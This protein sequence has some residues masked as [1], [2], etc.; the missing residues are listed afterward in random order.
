MNLIIAVMA[1]LLFAPSSRAANICDSYLENCISENA[2]GASRSAWSAI[3]SYN[4]AILAEMSSKAEA[5]F[6]EESSA[7]SDIGEEDQTIKQKLDVARAVV[8]KEPLGPIKP[9]DG[10]FALETMADQAELMELTEAYET[11]FGEIDYAK[12]FERL[13]QPTLAGVSA[14]FSSVQATL[15]AAINAKTELPASARDKMIERVKRVKYRSAAQAVRAGN[16]SELQLECGSSYHYAG[17]DLDLDANTVTLCPAT[18]AGRK[19]DELIGSF[20]AALYE[21][22]DLGSDEFKPLYRGYLACLNKQ[23]TGQQMQLTKSDGEATATQSYWIFETIFRYRYDGKR[24][25][26]KTAKSL[27]IACNT[28]VLK[29][30]LM[31][32]LTTVRSYANHFNCPRNKPRCDL[33]GSVNADG[34]AG[35]N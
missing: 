20:A 23:G 1:S 16:I 19:P 25:E 10:N 2:A 6:M 21:A 34:E 14:A 3:R 22:A 4:D 5:A 17:F 32:S 11:K 29:D 8:R 12:V 24:D 30:P 13:E 31:T 26:A 18:I 15:I 9:D 33:G 35:S 28:P 27:W 7:Q